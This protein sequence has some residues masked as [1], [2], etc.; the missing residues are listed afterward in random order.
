MHQIPQHKEAQLGQTGG[1]FWPHPLDLT[2]GCFGIQAAAG[3]PGPSGCALACQLEPRWGHGQNGLVGLVNGVQALPALAHQALA[4]R[5]AQTAIP[6]EGLGKLPEALHL[7][8]WQRRFW[9]LVKMAGQKAAEAFLA[10]F[11]IAKAAIGF[12]LQR[13]LQ[14]PQPTLQGV[15]I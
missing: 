3:G 6:L 1:R 2:Q 7:L 9:T 4:P 5:Q 15:G 12:Q 10:A 14:G 8:G 13:L 11:E